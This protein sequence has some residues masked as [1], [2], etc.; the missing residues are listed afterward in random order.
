[1]LP[2]AARRVFDDA[3]GASSGSP[4]R[5]RAPANGPAADAG[6]APG[7]GGGATD[8]VAEAEPDAQPVECVT[9]FEIG[10]RNTAIAA[11][12]AAVATTCQRD[13]IALWEAC[14]AQQYPTRELAPWLIQP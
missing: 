10:T 9:V 7:A 3:A 6:G 12:N 14:T 13:Q 1:M 4:A 5:L 11:Y 8:G 2:G